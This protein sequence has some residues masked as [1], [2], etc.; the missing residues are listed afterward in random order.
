[1]TL[2]AIDILHTRAK[3]RGTGFSLMSEAAVSPS[4]LSALLELTDLVAHRQGDARS[5]RRPRPR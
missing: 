1:M 4:V 2:K 3:A 5:R